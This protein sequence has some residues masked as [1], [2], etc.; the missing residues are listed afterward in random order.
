[1]I[2]PKIL[3]LNDYSPEAFHAMDYVNQAC[4]DQD[5]EIYLVSVMGSHFWDIDARLKFHK[6]IRSW[7]KQHLLVRNQIFDHN[8]EALQHIQSLNVSFD[9]VTTGIS[10]NKS[11]IFNVDVFDLPKLDIGSIAVIAHGSHYEQLNCMAFVMDESL[12]EVMETPNRLIDLACAQNIEINYVLIPENHL[13]ESGLKK[14][15]KLEK[16]AGHQDH[17]PF[18]NQTFSIAEQVLDRVIKNCIPNAIGLPV[19]RNRTIQKDRILHL[20][21]TIKKPIFLL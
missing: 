8:F 3:V 5:Y 4:I 9:F 11:E 16:V 15:R 6:L 19:K 18:Q 12:F 1:M 14:K 7:R 17:L 2:T 21:T 10:T 13:H 20:A